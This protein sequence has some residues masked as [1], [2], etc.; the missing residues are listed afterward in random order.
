MQELLDISLRLAVF[1][2]SILS[3]RLPQNCVDKAI[4]PSGGGIR[5]VITLDG[6]QL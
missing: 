6:S 2:R 5:L 1:E 3:F 4:A